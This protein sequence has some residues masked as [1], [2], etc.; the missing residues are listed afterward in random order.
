M[1]LFE[2]TAFLL[3]LLTQANIEPW[4]NNL[5]KSPLTPPG[6]VFSIVWTILYALLAY[7]AWFLWRYRKASDKLAIRLYGLQIIMNWAW[8]P[9]FFHFHWIKISAI[10][11]I[12]LTCLNVALIVRIRGRQPLIALLLLPYVFWLMFASYLNVFI[13]IMN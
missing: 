13:A 3:G 1:V 5:H 4:Y 6:V 12:T 2:T 8:T 9:L 7:I 10:W 11:L